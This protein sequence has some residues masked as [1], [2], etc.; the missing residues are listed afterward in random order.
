MTAIVLDMSGANSQRGQKREGA[1]LLRLSAGE[2][3]AINAA[4]TAAR[5]EVSTWARCALLGLVGGAAAVTPTPDPRQ[6]PLP[7]GTTEAP[8]VKAPAKRKPSKP[9]K[10]QKTAK[11]TPKSGSKKGRGK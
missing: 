5:L 9:S 7:V 1:I 4:A 6:L 3:A 10:P 8:V 2:R 11:P